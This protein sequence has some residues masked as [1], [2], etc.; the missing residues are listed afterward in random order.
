MQTNK[1]HVV[2]WPAN[3][4]MRLRNAAVVVDGNKTKL[5]FETLE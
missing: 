2:I 4:E 5:S 1:G 3:A